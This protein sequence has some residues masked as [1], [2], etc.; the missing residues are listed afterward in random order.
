MV[1]RGTKPNSSMISSLSRAS[2]RCRL[3]RRLS[4]RASMSSWTRAA[5]VVKPS[6]IPLLTGGQ[7]QAQGDVGLAGA[8][9]SDGDDILPVLDVFTAR[10]FHDQGFVHRRNGQEV[11]G[12]QAFDRGEAG[13]PNAALYHALVPVDEFQFGE[14]QQVVRVI[15]ALGGALGGQLAVLPEESW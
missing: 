8:T 15:R 11:E 2:C 7:V 1:D 9:I 6:D 13:G 5:A 4:S 14:T 12:I 10:Q 3:S